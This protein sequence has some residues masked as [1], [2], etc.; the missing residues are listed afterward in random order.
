MSEKKV[1]AIE[2]AAPT[3]LMEKQVPKVFEN[4]RKAG[5]FPAERRLIKQL[6]G[7]FA[8]DL[9]RE[10]FKR[11]ASMLGVRWIHEGEAQS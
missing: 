4:L 9:T 2:F 6:N 1:N 11:F 8:T 5:Y 10:E 7:K 3:A